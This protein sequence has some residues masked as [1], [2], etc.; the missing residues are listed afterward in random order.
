MS[1]WNNPENN[2]MKV[3]LVIV[4]LGAV[5]FGIFKLAGK[6]DSNLQGSVFQGTKKVVKQTGQSFLYMKENGS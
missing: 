3:L 6:P 2:T 1:F 4:I 5:G